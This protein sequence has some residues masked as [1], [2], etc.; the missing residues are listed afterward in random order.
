MA[1]RVF[2]AIGELRAA[3]A[4]EIDFQKRLWQGDCDAAL[5]SAERVLAGLRASDLRGYRALWHYLA[6]S[7]AWANGEMSLRKAR[8][9]F[10]KAKNAASSIRWLVGLAR[11]QAGETAQADVGSIVMEQIE[12]V[13]SILEHLGPVYHQKYTTREKVILDGLR[14]ENTRSFEEAHKLLGEMLGFEV[15]NVEEDASPDPWW[16]AGKIS[17]VFEDHS[18]AQ[19]NSVLDATKAR[20]A[21]SH[22]AWMR[23]NVD[24]GVDADVLP[25]LVTPVRRAYKGAMPHLRGVALWR[26]EEFREWAENAM[27]VMRGLGSAFSE[28]GDLAWQGR[29]RR[30]FEE[31]RLDAA[32]L[33]DVLREG[34]AAERLGVE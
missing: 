9:H 4:H 26:L 17:L 14:S 12:R 27:Q 31:H 33:Q 21:S 16:I 24:V 23:A 34:D 8:E 25:V 22:P 30:E 20:Q 28:A 10:G 1:Q 11:Y 19:E 5:E 32:G 29:A 2:P 7:A 13:E 18:G 3:V 6:G 15:G